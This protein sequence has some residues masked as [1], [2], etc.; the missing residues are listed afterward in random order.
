MNSVGVVFIILAGILVLM[1]L[2]LVFLIKPNKRRDVSRFYGKRYAHRGLHDAQIPENSKTA[3]RRAKEQGYGVELDVQMTKDGQ[4]VVFHDGTL[5]RMCGAEGYLRDY[6][7]EELQSLSLKGTEEKIPRFDEVLDIL[8]DV[9]LI[10]E[11]KSDNGIKNDNIC[12]K[13]Y[14]RL[15]NYKGN[16]CMESFS[17]LLVEWFRAHHPE[18]IRGQL[19][20]DMKKEPGQ[21][22]IVNFALTH[23]LANFISR[24]DFIAYRFTDTRKFGYWLCKRLYRPFCIA[25]T[26]RGTNEIKAAE[27]EFET[28]IFEREKSGN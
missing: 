4:L 14:E 12:K 18:V 20:C 25:W 2:A 6:T 10:C 28:I 1:M 7:Y 23:L 13:T 17:P 5:K 9:D 21:T 22:T 27:Q 8:E 11:I 26:A 19:S 16:W 24:P 3:F 15:A